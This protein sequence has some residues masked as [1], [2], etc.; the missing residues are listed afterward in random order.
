MPD[1]LW[2][3]GLIVGTI[4]VLVWIAVAVLIVKIVNDRR[5]DDTT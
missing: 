1:F 5:P 2:S 4:W 3:V